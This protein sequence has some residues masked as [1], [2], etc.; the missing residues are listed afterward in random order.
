MSSR[1]RREA[2]EIFESMDYMN[3]S[4]LWTRKYFFVY[5]CINTFGLCDS[6][7]TLQ[8]IQVSSFIINRTHG[9]QRGSGALILQ[10]RDFSPCRTKPKKKKKKKSNYVH[11]NSECI[12]SFLLRS[13]EYTVCVVP[14]GLL[15]A[16]LYF[17]VL[18]NEGNLNL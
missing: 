5:V 3:K 15:R 9:E 4:L 8:S 13:A 11:P 12:V 14:P 2:I 6:K 18:Y 7:I 17:V 16:L 1:E 10:S